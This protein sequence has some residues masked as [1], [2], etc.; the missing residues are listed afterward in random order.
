MPTNRLNYDDNYFEHTKMEFGDHIE[1]LRKHLIRALVGLGLGFLISL[2]FARPLFGYIKEPVESEL[3]R[4]IKDRKKKKKIKIVKDKLSET[5]KIIEAKL[6]TDPENATLKKQ[7][8]VIDELLDTSVDT[9]WKEWEEQTT[10]APEVSYERM[11]MYELK[12]GKYVQ[13]EFYR[14]VVSSE[15]NLLFTYFGR[16][17]RVKVFTIQEGFL[18][19]VKIALISGLVIASPW[20]FYQIW[21]FIAAGLYPHEKRLVHLYLP[22]SVGLFLSGVVFCQLVV[23]PPGVQALLGF[24]EWMG[25]EPELRASEW[26]N[27]ALILPVVFGVAF[28]T[29]IVML[30]LARVGICNVNMYRSYRK[31]TYFIMAVVS[32]VLT[33]Q[34]PYTMVGMLVPLIGFYELG[35]WLCIW[36][37]AEQPLFDL[38]IPD[39][40]EIVEV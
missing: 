30:A 12:E 32:A 1:E 22:F 25:T 38:E 13:R 26:L 16:T 19:F 4:I 8:G 27:F 20:V 10:V 36:L 3:Q 7:V 37:K 21:S 33:P 31:I 18:I 24:S 29:P 11:Q 28:Q 9:F 5:K 15:L 6:A 40:E 39:S 34:D 23:I 2:L 14:K 35:I 17:G